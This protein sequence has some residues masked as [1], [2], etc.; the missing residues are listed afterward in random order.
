MELAYNPNLEHREELTL[1][2]KFVTMMK[3]VVEPDM[4]VSDRA[5]GL[6]FTESRTRTALFQEL[7]IGSLAGARRG[8]G[9]LAADALRGRDRTCS[10]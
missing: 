9:I 6:G 7:L 10:A 4:G 1:R 3:T 2:T 5:A 8:R